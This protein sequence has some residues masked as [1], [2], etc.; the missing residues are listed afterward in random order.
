[1]S[2][3]TVTLSSNGRYWQLR[4][5]DHAGRR[6][7]KSLGPKTRLSRR[8]ARALRDRFAAELQVQPGRAT[9]GRA[10]RLGAF[11]ERCLAARTELEPGTRELYELT[12]K[13]LLAHFGSEVRIDRINRAG[14]SDWRAALAGGQFTRRPLRPATVCLHV[15]NAKA[16]F[17]SAM[18]DDLLLVNPFD[19]QK[20]QTPPSPK[21]WKYVSLDELE[22]LLSACPSQSWRT[23]LALCRLAGLR[24]GEALRLPW[25]AVDWSTM[26]MAVHDQKRKRVRP[27]PIEPRLQEILIDAYEQA[28]EGE[29]RV[30]LAGGLR[31]TNLW[32]DFRVIQKRAGLSAWA[33]WCHTLRKNCETDWAQRFPQYV[34]SAWIGHDITVSGEYYLQVP[35]ELYDKAAGLG[36]VD[37]ANTTPVAGGAGPGAAP[38]RR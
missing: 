14:A 15:R 25:N 19:R 10:P 22:L 38:K 4:Y 23:L 28:A 30:I 11:L 35:V 2:M 33:R 34:V 24:Q 7:C 29:Q 18:D 8:Q 21:T 26:R 12:R 9:A 16:V 37:A 1:M 6:R 13:Y 17:K 27:V 20:G 3:N 32:R 5:R 36:P 31:A